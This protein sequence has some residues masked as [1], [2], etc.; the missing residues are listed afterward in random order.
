MYLLMLL[1]LLHKTVGPWLSPSIIHRLPASFITSILYL[2]EM[3][4]R[5]K[6][7]HGFLLITEELDTLPP[8]CALG[9]TVWVGNLVSLVS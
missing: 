4:V 8:S 1:C 6:V 3:A 5:S 9:G 2:G 7:K